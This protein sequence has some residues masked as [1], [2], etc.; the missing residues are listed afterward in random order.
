MHH[1][2]SRGMLLKTEDRA[3]RRAEWDRWKKEKD[4]KF[5]EKK[6]E[7]E[8]QEREADEAT[9]RRLR[10]MTVHRA[11]PVPNFIRQQKK[12]DKPAAE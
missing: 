11:R 4:L 8:R 1:A 2:A 10:Q 7:R 12:P 9:T 6:Q 3:A 5:A